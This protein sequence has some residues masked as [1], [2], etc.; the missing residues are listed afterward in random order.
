MIFDKFAV[1]RHKKKWQQAID[2]NRLVSV[3]RVPGDKLLVLNMVEADVAGKKIANTVSNS[4]SL[5]TAVG[6]A[7]QS[8]LGQMQVGETRFFEITDREVDFEEVYTPDVLESS[9]RDNYAVFAE[10]NT[11]GEILV[12]VKYDPELE[13]KAMDFKSKPFLDAIQKVTGPMKPGDV[14]HFKKEEGE[15]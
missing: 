9:L 2:E 1:H 3:K 12:W 5:N 14:F 11:K 4:Y 13:P 6:E 15:A 7:L 8:I 10:M